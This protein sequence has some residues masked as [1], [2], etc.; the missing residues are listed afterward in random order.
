M[1]LNFKLCKKSIESPDEFW[2]S[3]AQSYLD[4]DT[5]WRSK[6]NKYQ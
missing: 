5:K 6:E 1:N 3:Q 2:A 4:W